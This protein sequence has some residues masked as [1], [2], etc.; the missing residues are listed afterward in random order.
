MI[1][2]IKLINISIPSQLQFFL[3]GGNISSLS[4]FRVYNAVLL[5]IA[6]VL[7]KRS[8]ELIHLETES[9]CWLKRKEKIQG[10]LLFVSKWHFFSYSYLFHQLCSL[11]TSS[12]IEFWQCHPRI[13][14][15]YRRFGVT[16]EGNGVVR[17]WID[18]DNKGVHCLQRI[19]VI[20]ALKVGLL[21]WPPCRGNAEQCWWQNILLHRV[22]SSH[23]VPPPLSHCIW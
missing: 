12:N 20:I 10:Y 6:T 11:V 9:Y 23:C 4:K 1:I 5:T 19:H 21:L 3:C 14:L 22:D 2:T 7:N 15:P 17:G 16:Y 13:S 8:L 18:I